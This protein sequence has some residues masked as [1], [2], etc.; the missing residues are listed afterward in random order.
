MKNPAP[1]TSGFDRRF[2]DVG[3]PDVRL[4]LSRPGGPE[5][6]PR[7]PAR[8]AANRSVDPPERVT[9]ADAPPRMLRILPRELQ[10]LS[11]PGDET[12]SS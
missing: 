2:D 8:D 9:S 7:P 4:R 1:P 5:S 12:V 10:G 11:R 6:I 3:E